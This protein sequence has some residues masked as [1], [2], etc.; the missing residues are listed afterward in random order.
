MAFGAVK[1][2][3]Y[4]LMNDAQLKYNSFLFAIIGGNLDIIHIFEKEAIVNFKEIGSEFIS[5]SYSY[6]YPSIAEYIMS[7]CDLGELENNIGKGKY[8]V[9]SLKVQNSIC[10]F[11]F[12]TFLE[13]L[14]DDIGLE[15]FLNEY[16]SDNSLYDCLIETYSYLF[17]TFLVEYNAEVSIITTYRV[18]L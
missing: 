5:Q 14:N 2:F 15:Y 7:L 8:S 10:S 9:I 1:I 11:D 12:S 18:H 6:H 3:K 13:C 17:Y 16:Y 4:L